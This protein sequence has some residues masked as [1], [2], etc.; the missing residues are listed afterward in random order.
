MQQEGLAGICEHHSC[1]S[2]VCPHRPYVGVEQHVPEE[3]IDVIVVPYVYTY[4]LRGELQRDQGPVAVGVEASVGELGGQKRSPGK[5]IEV[6]E[7]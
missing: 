3:H 6:S 5:T 2:T 1:A 7:P 4:G